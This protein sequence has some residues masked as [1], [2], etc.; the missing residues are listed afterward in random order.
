MADENSTLRDECWEWNGA[1]NDH[2]YGRKM[3]GSKESYT[4]RLAW[5]WA[6]GPIPS[7][8]H[9]CHSCDNPPCCNPHH[10]FLGTREDNM[11]D[12]VRKGRHHNKNK[13]TCRA[14]HK[15]SGSNLRIYRGR[16]E[17]RACDA[18]RS[19][20]YQAKLRA[21]RAIRIQPSS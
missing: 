6:N 11:R 17:C 1:R 20:K 3:S 19:R 15:Y 8:G 21:A 13:V 7:G 14:G 10:L 5:T 16:R 12:S 18:A 9:I 2:G 4:H